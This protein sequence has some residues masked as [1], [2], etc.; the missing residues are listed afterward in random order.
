MSTTLTR[1]D[2]NRLFW[3]FVSLFLIGIVSVSAIYIL[4]MYSQ[5][6]AIFG[7]GQLLPNGQAYCQATGTST[8]ATS[9]P[10][11]CLPTGQFLQVTLVDAGNTATKLSGWSSS[12]VDPQANGQVIDSC[13]NTGSNGQCTFSAVAYSPG[14]ALRMWICHQTT[15]CGTSA[16]A[17]QKTVIDVGFPG[18]PGAPG[19]T[20]PFWVGTQ[21]PTAT[22][23]QAFFLPV[24]LLAG[25]AATANAPITNLFQLANGTKIATGLTCFQNQAAGTNPCYLGSGVKIPTFTFT[26]SHNFV[27]TNP[28]SNGFNTFPYSNFPIRGTL[29]TVLRLELKQAA[30]SDPLCVMSSS[31][32][33]SGPWPGTPTAT[34]QSSTPDVFYISGDQ[35]TTLTQ[36]INQDGSIASSGAQQY[37]FSVDCT[38]MS[39]SGDKTSFTLDLV[40]Y[41][42]A[43]YFTSTNGSTNTE[44]VTQMT[45]FVV[46]VQTP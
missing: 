45:Q 5:R 28:Y 22:P 7:T 16:F 6:A 2:K 35:G 41:F 8:S 29:T 24:L 30:G 33:G 25:D 26:L 14:R 4:P 12:L 44:A 3:L 17:Q 31:G 34:K 37:S 20:V 32:A 43:S 40:T 19:G 15:A 36:K 46:T 13:L 42:S 21:A 9:P 23:T 18:L 11:G 27:G 39:T 10:S 38:G 1:K